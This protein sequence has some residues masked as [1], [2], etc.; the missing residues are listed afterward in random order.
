MQQLPIYSVRWMPN[1]FFFH[2]VIC[3]FCRHFYYVFISVHTLAEQSS[4]F[5]TQWNTC[6]A[7]H[8]TGPF[9]EFLEISMQS[10]VSSWL[11]IPTSDS[12]VLSHSITGG[13]NI[14]ISMDSGTLSPL[15]PPF[16]SCP[17]NP[18]HVQKLQSPVWVRRITSVLV[19]CW[20][21]SPGSLL[22]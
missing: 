19:C 5:S 6:L 4:L 10:Q 22:C 11:F 14:L 8:L 12:E 18:K 13:Q 1:H 17:H 15:T 9:Q 16:S 2:T 20:E 21:S 7:H 3:L